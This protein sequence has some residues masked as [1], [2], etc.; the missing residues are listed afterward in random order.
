[1]FKLRHRDSCPTIQL[2]VM[3]QEV[4][5]SWLWNC[6]CTAV[7]NTRGT[8]TELLLWVQVWGLRHAWPTVWTWLWFL[9]LAHLRTGLKHSDRLNRSDP[10][11][12]A[13]K[14]WLLSEGTNPVIMVPNEVHRRYW[15]DLLFLDHCKHFDVLDPT[16]HRKQFDPNTLVR[17]ETR[18]AKNMVF[19]H[20]AAS[21]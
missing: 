9:S 10:H 16:V 13:L 14:F 11:H 8:A 19:D 12:L 17:L 2:P 21:R 20:V 5:P 1:M 4:T 7:L 18:A 15:L 3:V 6:D